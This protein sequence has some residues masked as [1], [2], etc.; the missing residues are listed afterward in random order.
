M[1]EKQ[2]KRL[3]RAIYGDN[4]RRPVEYVRLLRTGQCRT[5]GLRSQY[6]AAKRG[7]TAIEVQGDSLRESRD[8][9]SGL[10]REVRE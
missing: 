1:N 8:G 2:A 7:T 3:R 10:A 4:A 9:E 5:V 6:Q